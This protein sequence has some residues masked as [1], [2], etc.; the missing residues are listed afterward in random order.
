MQRLI[1]DAANL[2]GV[3]RGHA[4]LAVQVGTPERMERA[5]REILEAADRGGRLVTEAREAERRS[6]EDAGGAD[7]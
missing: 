3:I 2:L 6:E 5:L 7:D 4:E 1:H